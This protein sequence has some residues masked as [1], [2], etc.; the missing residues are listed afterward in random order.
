[1]EYISSA[2]IKSRTSVIVRY[3][4]VGLGVLSFF[5][6]AL[7][8]SYTYFIPLAA[9]KLS[10]PL[11]YHVHGA[12]YF[13]WIL[14]IIVQPLLVR[15]RRPGIHRSVG[16][17]GF[18]LAVGMFFIGIVMS[19]VSGTR[20]VSAGQAEEAR[21]FLIVP[22]T[23]MIFFGTFAGL[24]LMN[25]KNP[26]AHKR[27]MVLATLSILPA[28]FGRI[29]G[30]NGIDPGTATGFAIAILLQESLLIL[31]VIHDF[32]AKRRI[33]PVYRWG[34]AAVVAVHITRVALGKTEW[35]TTIAERIIG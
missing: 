33:H 35:W 1:M 34:G 25:L 12:M 18:S 6:V 23:D 32:T 3:F 14:L 5:F 28:A 17:F 2:I 20:Y 9:G 13:L 10:V 8:F 29:L 4:Y 22:F 24:S 19:I 11:V 31:G 30:V 26:E 7:G 21:S 15:H 27:L 16:Y